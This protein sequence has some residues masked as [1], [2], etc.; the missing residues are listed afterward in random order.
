VTKAGEIIGDALNRQVKQ[1]EAA[2]QTAAEIDAQR[3]RAIAEGVAAL[4]PAPSAT[5]SESSK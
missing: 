3:E 5:P 1:Q 4:E 2:K